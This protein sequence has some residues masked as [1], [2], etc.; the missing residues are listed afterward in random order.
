[1]KADALGAI[2][3]ERIVLLDGAAGT[4]LYAR[5]MTPGVCPE[6]WA[7]E[8]PTALSEVH[9]AYFDVG[10][11]VVYTFTLGANRI[12]MRG[13]NLEADVGR[14]NERLARTTV[15]I[16]P[17]GR[18]VA[19]EIGSTGELVEPF[20][21]LPFDEAVDVYKEQIRG[22]VA[23]GVHLLVIETML[24]VQE[25]RAALIACKETTDL[26]VLVSMTFSQGERTLTGTPPEAAAVILQ[27]LGAA[28]V[29]CNCSTGPQAMRRIVER[30]KPV[31][32]V[33]L[34]AKPNAGLPRV[35]DGLTVFDMGPEE[36]GRETAA[37]VDAGAAVVGGCCGTTPQHITALRERIAA[38]TPH[39]P[40]PDG[41]LRLASARR[42]VS[43]DPTG[44]ITVIGERINPT[45]KKKL[46]KALRERRLE[47]VRRIAADQTSAGADLL[48]VNV[49]MHGVD[50]TA[51]M[52]D[53]VK[54][55]SSTT[56]APLCLDSSSPQTLA[57]ALRV[58]PGRALVNSV[59]AERKK[60]E[61][62]LPIAARYGAA[63]LVLPLTDD[64]IPK[65]AAE[66]ATVVERIFAKAKE[67][68]YTKADM[69]VDGLVLTISSDADAA[70][71]TLETV[72]WA[73]REFGVNA[74]MGLSNV[75]FG[76]PQR[77]WLNGAF[78]AMGIS[79]GMS[80][81]IA[82]PSDEVLTACRLAADALCGRD[83]DCMRYVHHFAGATEE[84]TTL[85][86]GEATARPEEA[87]RRAVIRGD[88]EAV[89][90]LV[91]AA[92]DA[93]TPPF[94][95]VSEHLI[96]AI[97]EV[98]D[99]FERHEY[100]LPQLMLS[101]ETMERAF[102]I[103]RPLLEEED[104]PRAGTVVIAT[105]KG[106]VHDI[107]KNIV[108]LMLR[109]HGFDVVDLG[110]DVDARAIVDRAETEGADLIG[111][112]ALMTTTMTE[113]PKVIAEAQRRKL[114]A[115]VIVGGAVV[116]EAYAKEI[117][118]DGYARDAVGAA[119]LAVDLLAKKK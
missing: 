78:L 69:A 10:C 18:H 97:T 26:P 33:P 85:E 16:A 24:D 103:V 17:A 63:I 53:V 77:K 91:R 43:P 6:M 89:E 62:L 29:G 107:G 115:R 111:L 87:A 34:L 31:A 99:K 64:G 92:L 56:D 51:L 93:G 21:P 2:L 110:K 81:V 67:C 57:A 50:E 3:E 14:L 60:L 7:A 71:Q 94:A 88:R 90:E 13:H 68:G 104:A 22:L 19:G 37:L 55:L 41:T 52:V 38:K 66:R 117:G 49:G 112:S 108:A 46:Q 83:R 25:T 73:A 5:G 4:E 39:I 36:F 9:R 113:M 105:V 42:V 86:T 118:A 65:T 32:R 30:M 15:D 28:V 23:G 20:G 45:G 70:R 48:D 72:R 1:M 101:A 61:N 12:K 59:S 35:V 44:P 47:V 109:N 116:T 40:G 100:F 58:Y 95:L 11:D 102:A 106:D 74:L 119:R 54:M 114:S 84:N 82:D 80:M 98:G 76:L 75:S 27:S 79:E 8:N 96:P